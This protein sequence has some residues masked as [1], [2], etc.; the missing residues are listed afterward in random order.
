MAERLFR[1]TI[2]LA[3]T[4][5]QEITFVTN[6]VKDD[7]QLTAIAYAHADPNG[8]K[9]TQV[10]RRSL[11]REELFNPKEPVEEWVPTHFLRRN[12]DVKIR[13]ISA[14]GAGEFLGEDASGQRDEYAIEYWERI[15]VVD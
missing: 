13:W 11:S 14:L 5:E 7:D 4:D 2:R 9:T 12:P 15:N 1:Y 6:E 10:V 3:V 8:W